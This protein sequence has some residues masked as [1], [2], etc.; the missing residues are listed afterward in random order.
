M[1][2]INDT[3]E[4]GSGCEERTTAEYGLHGVYVWHYITEN[5][6]IRTDFPCNKEINASPSSIF[7]GQQCHKSPNIGIVQC[8]ISM[9]PPNE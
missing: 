5:S 6:D 1:A 8:E 4:I 2:S 7:S 9:A 3:I